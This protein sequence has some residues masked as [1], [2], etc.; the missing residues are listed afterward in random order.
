MDVVHVPPWTLPRHRALMNVRMSRDGGAFD[1]RNQ[2]GFGIVEINVEK[3]PD[4]F[5]IPF[6]R[7][8]ALMPHDGGLPLTMPRDG[9]LMSRCVETASAEVARFGKKNPEL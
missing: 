2:L 8:L 3:S 6:R 1:A 9:H 4:I 7:T 5:L